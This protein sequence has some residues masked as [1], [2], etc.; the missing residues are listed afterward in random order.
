VYQVT[1]DSPLQADIIDAFAKGVVLG[2]GAEQCLPAKMEIIS[3]NVA[4]VTLNEGKYHQVRRMFA[5]CG[6]HVEALHRSQFGEYKL[7]DLAQGEWRN[8]FV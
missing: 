7:Q 5:A 1:V 6:Y 8:L 4:N 3:D 2:E